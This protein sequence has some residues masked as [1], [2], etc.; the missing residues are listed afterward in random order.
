LIKQSF[1]K[2]AAVTPLRFTET[3]SSNSDLTIGFE[4]FDGFG[5]VLAWAYSPE[6]GKIEFDE[7]E[8]WTT[9]QLIEVGI[10][11]IGHAIGLSHSSV[12]GTIMWPACCKGK[13]DLH[14][15]DI[16]GIQSIYGDSTGVIP[17]NVPLVTNVPD[18]TYGPFP[19]YPGGSN[20]NCRDKVGNCVKTD[21]NCAWKGAIYYCARTC[22]FKCPTQA[23]IITLPPGQCKDKASNCAQLKGICDV[24]NILLCDSTCRRC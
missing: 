16:N 20:D 13:S 12:R 10:H 23:P 11:E 21:K 18:P 9:S 19:T 17:T 7:D 3:T 4:P 6:H 22:G 2:W 5:R 8:T 24:P 14:A 1:E 15:D